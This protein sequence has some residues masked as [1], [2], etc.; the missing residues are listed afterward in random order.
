MRRLPG[1]TTGAAPR[2]TERARTSSVQVPLEVI[3][4]P[5]RAGSSNDHEFSGMGPLLPRG[6][7]EDALPDPVPHREWMSTASTLSK[8]PPSEPDSEGEAADPELPDA[9]H[10]PITFEPIEPMDAVVGEDG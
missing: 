10:C 1:Q 8:A 4:T 6:R 3:Q 7:N 2:P 9:F 5:Q